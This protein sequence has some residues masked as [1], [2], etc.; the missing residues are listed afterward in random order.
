MGS[1]GSPVS[2]I[3]LILPVRYLANADEDRNRDTD[4]HPCCSTTEEPNSVGAL[5]TLRPYKAW[6]SACENKVQ[7]T[8]Q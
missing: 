3:R 6:R 7:R 4:A 8:C 2:E 1:G 5:D